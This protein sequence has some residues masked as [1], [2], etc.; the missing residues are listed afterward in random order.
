M[1]STR[2]VQV[3]PESPGI[4]HAMVLRLIRGLPGDR[5]CLPPS[6]ANMA[7][8]NPVGPTCLHELDA[9]VEAPEHHDFAVRKSTVRQRAVIRSRAF[10]DP[11]CK[12]VSRLMLPRP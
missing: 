1:E 2:E 9:R 4:P 12:H 7:R 10:F 6:S 8:L 3:T 11:P 5:P